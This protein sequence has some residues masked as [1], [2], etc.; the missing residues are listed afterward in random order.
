MNR[1]ARDELR[2]DIDE[3]QDELAEL[4]LRIRDESRVETC[5]DNAGEILQ[6]MR[7]RTG[8]D[9][10]ITCNMCGK[11]IES[12]VYV[13]LNDKYVHRECHM[14]GLKAERDAARA[15][16]ANVSG[17]LVDSGV[18]VPDDETRYGE[19]VREIMRE[20]DAARASEKAMGE[21]VRRLVDRMNQNVSAPTGVFRGHCK[22]CY[23]SAT[24]TEETHYK[25]CVLAELE[26]IANGDAP[27][28]DAQ[29]QATATKIECK[30]GCGQPLD[31]HYVER[32][33]KDGRETYSAVKC[34]ISPSDDSS[35][36]HA[37]KNPWP[38]HCEKP[39]CSGGCCT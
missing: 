39:G 29:P 28:A 36:T 18:V 8:T 7:S 6:R 4:R 38:C 33:F 20:R 11:P 15:S 35:S 14:A 25:D 22:W 17:A 2:L 10:N 32:Q 19:A 27:P 5:L 24:T 26:S 23:M 31:Q 1:S 12:N 34:P 21:R 9:M 3:L 30:H 37:I 13:R 16:I